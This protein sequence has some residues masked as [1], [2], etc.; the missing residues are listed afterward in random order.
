MKKNLKFSTAYMKIINEHVVKTYA[1][2]MPAEKVDCYYVRT[3]RLVFDVAAEAEEVSL[4]SEL[5]KDQQ[6]LTPLPLILFNFRIVVFAEVFL[7]YG[8]SII[9]VHRKS[10]KCW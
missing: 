4:N 10:T 1:R 2:E 9:T 8:V 6:Q 3:S 5:L 7:V